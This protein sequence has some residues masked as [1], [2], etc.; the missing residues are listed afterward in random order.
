MPDFLTVD[1]LAERFGTTSDTMARRID[2]AIRR[3]RKIESREV[4]VQRRGAGWMRAWNVDDVRNHAVL[5]LTK[6]G[7]HA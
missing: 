7:R 2:R 6:G 3:G 5:G 1:Q 4:P